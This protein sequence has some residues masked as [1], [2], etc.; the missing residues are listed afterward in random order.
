MLE[1][2]L[3][4]RGGTDKTRKNMGLFI[5]YIHVQL[6]PYVQTYKRLVK[7]DI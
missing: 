7:R 5:S 3:A 2:Q 6:A 1:K 4:I